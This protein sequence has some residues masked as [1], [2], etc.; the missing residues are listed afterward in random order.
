M[1][2]KISAFLM[3]TL[4]AFST[5]A[6]P[7]T[8]LNHSFEVDNVANDSAS[9]DNNSWIETSGSSFGTLDRNGPSYGA[10]IAPTPD[11]DGEQLLWSNIGTL[12][13]TLSDGLAANTTYDVYVDVG[14]RQFFDFDGAE[15]RLG[16]GSTAG[17]N[18]LTPTS[19]V[20][21]TPNLGWETWQYTFTTGASPAGEGQALRVEL[22]NPNVGEQTL[23]DN[24]RI[25]ANVVPEPTTFSLFALVIAG[26]ASRRFRKRF[27]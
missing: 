8:V 23:F 12:Y 6:D 21:P 10:V 19:V 26:V 16:Y 9:Q 22:Y 24:V 18:L 25:N 11:A 5:Q 1:K 4:L 15:I 7:I 27:S 2:L 14:H 20:N 3:G 17:A 13:Q